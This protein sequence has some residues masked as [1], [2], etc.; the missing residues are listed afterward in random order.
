MVYKMPMYKLFKV[1]YQTSVG[2]IVRNWY[3]EDSETAARKIALKY[4]KEM[5]SHLV[6]VTEAEDTKLTGD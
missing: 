3:A 6:E 2:P 5:T 4:H 1:K